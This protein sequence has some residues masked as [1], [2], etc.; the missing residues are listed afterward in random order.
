MYS[1]YLVLLKF[2][3]PE[4]VV[5]YVLLSADMS[6]CMLALELKF[7]KTAYRINL[8][9]VNAVG[10]PCTP[11]LFPTTRGHAT[12]EIDRCHCN[13]GDRLRVINDQ[14][15][16]STLCIDP[17]VQ[18]DIGLYKVSGREGGRGPWDHT[19]HIWI[20]GSTL[21]FHQQWYKN[22]IRLEGKNNFCR[23]QKDR[24]STKT[25]VDLQ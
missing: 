18:S 15:G 19:C 3:T 13:F 10:P 5:I 22:K 14:N 25:K 12:R 24:Q 23:D 16:R 17:A 1:L 21:N 4:I 20:P 2:F 6:H 9:F 7:S 11:I 8:A